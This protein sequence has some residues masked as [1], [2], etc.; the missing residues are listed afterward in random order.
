[1]TQS[2]AFLMM[3]LADL[4]AGYFDRDEDHY[5]SGD[6][7]YYVASKYVS[8]KNEFC[9]SG[10]DAQNVP[11]WGGLIKPHMAGTYYF[12][13]SNTSKKSFMNNYETF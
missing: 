9:H 12:I 1:M 4:A 11:V 10:V 5:L 13:T 3:P 2:P 6:A 8:A 7:G